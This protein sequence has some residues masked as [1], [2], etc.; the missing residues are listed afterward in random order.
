MMFLRKKMK[1]SGYVAVRR[2]DNEFLLIEKGSHN[3]EL[4]PTGSS[5]GRS[6]SGPGLL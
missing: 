1:N 3:T 4:E 2:L 6:Q 5:T